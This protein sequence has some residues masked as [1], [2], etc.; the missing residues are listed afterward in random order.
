MDDLGDSERSMFVEE[1]VKKNIYN[2]CDNIL[3]GVE[4]ND[5][6]ID[7]YMQ[8]INDN[9]IQELYNYNKPYKYNVSVILQ[10]YNNS[11]SN[12]TNNNNLH[13]SESMYWDSVC[14]TVCHIVYP[15]NKKNVTLQHNSIQAII[16]VFAVSFYT[17]V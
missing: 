13:I 6:Y 10:Q 11:N 5:L 9:I 7:N 15:N 8:Q 12:N 3:N 14:D 1:Y 4:Y 16:T 17:A 2:I